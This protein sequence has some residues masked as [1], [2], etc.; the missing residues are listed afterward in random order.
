[1]LAKCLTN[2]VGGGGDFTSWQ[3]FFVT[4]IDLLLITNV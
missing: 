1:M 2:V 3:A 4:D